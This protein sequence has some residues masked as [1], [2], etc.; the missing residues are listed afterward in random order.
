MAQPAAVAIGAGMT[1]PQSGAPQH[2]L[3]VTGLTALSALIQDS[4]AGLGPINNNVATTNAL[5]SL[6]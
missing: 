6:I 5:N 1:M 3:P 4:C 2:H